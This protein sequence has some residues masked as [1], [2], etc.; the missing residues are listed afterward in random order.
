MTG[1]VFAIGDS[2]MQGAGPD[3]YATLPARWPGI[4]VDAVPNRQM[5]HAPPL[6]TERL[7]RTP[8]P[9]TIVVHLG[10][11]GLF[12]E[13]T[14]DDVVAAAAGVPLLLLTMKA[15][16]D[17]EAAV[18]ERLA[19]GVERHASHAGLLDW[20]AIATGGPSEHLRPDGFHLSRTGAVAYAD[21]IAEALAR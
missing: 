1:P 20:H 10:T 17:W 12:S 9:D 11:N 13:A 8:R 18:N 21:A 15:P 3:L 16:R 6:V 4:E 7:T 2:V 14:L 5:W 19:L